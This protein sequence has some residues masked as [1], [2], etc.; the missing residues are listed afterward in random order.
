MLL[1]NYTLGSQRTRLCCIGVFLAAKTTTFETSHPHP[2]ETTKITILKFEKLKISNIKEKKK[3]G[4]LM[5]HVACTWAGLKP[6][7]REVYSVC[8]DA[9]HSQFW[10]QC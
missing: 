7:V 3:K 2:P 10:K 5:G 1:F 8:K 4:I 6:K 9:G